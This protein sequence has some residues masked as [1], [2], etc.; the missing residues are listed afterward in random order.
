MPAMKKPFIQTNDDEVIIG[1]II[2]K[3]DSPLNTDY[4]KQFMRRND[5]LMQIL[6]SNSRTQPI[7]LSK[8]RGC[9]LKIIR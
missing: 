7:N 9:S 5:Q 4:F 6:K 1:N 2:V 3:T 8:V